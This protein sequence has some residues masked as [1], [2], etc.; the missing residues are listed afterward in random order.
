M[1]STGNY[2]Q[3]LVITYNGKKSEKKKDMCICITESLCCMPETN[4]T[5]NQLYFNNF[6][7][8]SG[9]ATSPVIFFLIVPNKV[10]YPF[11][12]FR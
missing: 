11:H 4:T 5:L 6:F 1:Y 2:S 10:N 9:K 7:K 3:Y 12:V 8:L